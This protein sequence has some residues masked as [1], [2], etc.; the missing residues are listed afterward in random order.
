MWTS[1][2]T[3]RAQCLSRPINE[4]FIS[5][6]SQC[7]TMRQWRTMFS[8][9]LR[10]GLWVRDYWDTGWGGWKRGGWQDPQ[11]LSPQR[12]MVHASSPRSSP[13]GGG[14]DWG[15]CRLAAISLSEP[16]PVK[17]HRLPRN[18]AGRRPSGATWRWCK[19]CVKTAPSLLRLFIHP[20]RALRGIW[21]ILKIFLSASFSSCFG[22]FFM[23]SNQMPFAP[24][25]FRCRLSHMHTSTCPELLFNYHWRSVRLLLIFD[26]IPNSSQMM[27]KTK[28]RILI[29]KASAVN[30]L[31]G[32]C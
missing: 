31:P 17:M 14:V 9:Q 20:S 25:Y 5:L 11:G 26:K 7:W 10:W 19:P 2:T 27:L 13:L 15:A 18:D 29:Y 22:G 24:L 1:R 23:T 28:D 12:S 8:D 21:F 32:L 4:I 16:G 30:S 3:Q 6:R